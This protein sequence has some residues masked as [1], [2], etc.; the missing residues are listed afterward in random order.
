MA[1]ASLQQLISDSDRRGIT[2]ASHAEGR[3][4][5][6]GPPP[7][8]GVAIS[9]KIATGKSW[10]AG[11]ILRHNKPRLP[12]KPKR[13]MALA[14]ELKLAVYDALSCINPNLFPHGP[15]TERLAWVNE[16]KPSL[17]GT[18]Q[19]VGLLM[20][21]EMGESYW[22]DRM[23]QRVYT[24]STGKGVQP[25][26]FIGVVDDMRFKSEFKALKRLNFL[27]VRL[28][29]FPFSRAVYIK[30]RTMLY[31]QLTAVQLGHSSE[32]DLDDYSAFD[33]VLDCT[34][35]KEEVWRDYYARAKMFTWA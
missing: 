19:E 26:G 16:H 35:P 21:E 13:R 22:V 29:V 5:S 3:S 12:H 32:C 14:D 33:I 24:G 6:V 34:K 17:R 8:R 30:R 15:V 4:G 31:P 7:V 20:R 18:L 11:E 27:T 25:G 23:F 1:R 2:S 10:L 28:E 9:G